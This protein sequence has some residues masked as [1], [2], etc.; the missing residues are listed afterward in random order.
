MYPF[1]ANLEKSFLRMKYL[2]FLYF[3]LLFNFLVK[4]KIKQKRFILKMNRLCHLKI[5]DH[6]SN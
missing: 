1:S 2:Q 6:V 4:N 3:E 5:K